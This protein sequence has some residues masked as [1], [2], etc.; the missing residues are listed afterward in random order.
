MKSI[1]LFAAAMLS[2]VPGVRAADGSPK[3]QI[4]TATKALA[5]KANYSWRMTTVVPEDSPFK[6]GPWDGKAEKDGFTQ[7]S[8]SFGDNTSQFVLKGDK[9]AVSGPDGGWQSLSELEGSEGPGRF[10][11]IIIRNFKA[12]AAQ[13]GQLLSFAKEIK[14]DNDAFAADLTE[15]GAKTL[16]TWRPSGGDEGPKVSNAQ[17]SVKFWLKEGALVKYEFKLKGTVSFNNNEFENDRITTVELKDVGATKL[18][19][20]DEAKK[21]LL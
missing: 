13:A 11:G 3:E 21:K 19:V 12:P 18:T 20:P 15:E 6:P 16:L 9:G 14:K 8:M 1:S 10:F 2:L 4:Q 7:V 5:E 17:G